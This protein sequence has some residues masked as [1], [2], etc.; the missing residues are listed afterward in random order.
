MSRRLTERE[1]EVLEHLVQG[2][3]NAAIAQALWIQVSTVKAHLTSVFKKLGVTN[4]VEAIVKVKDCAKINQRIAASFKH[5]QAVQK[6]FAQLPEPET[7]EGNPN[8]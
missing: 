4:R 8:E 7:K 1:R 2:K 3:S 6:A 5:V